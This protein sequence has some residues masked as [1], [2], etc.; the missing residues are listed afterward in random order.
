MKND[1]TRAHPD[2]GFDDHVPV[3][4]R[5]FL[6]WFHV[7]HVTADEI[8]P[9]IP[10]MNKHLGAKHDMV[11]NDDFRPGGAKVGPLSEGHMV[12]AINGLVA[13]P[14][15]RIEIKTRAD[16]GK[17]GAVKRRH[18]NVA[19]FKHESVNFP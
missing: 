19:K 15:T 6:A 9:V 13:I 16:P 3:V 14:S 12:S 18:K 8:R 1:G 17:P 11:A 10:A 7:I 2:I 5:P 4:F